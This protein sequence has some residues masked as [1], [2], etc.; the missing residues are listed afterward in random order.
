MQ[1]P[2]AAADIETLHAEEAREGDDALARALALVRFLRLRCPWDAKQT[3]QTLRPYLLE[4][5]H[6]V[7][8]AIRA[9]DD[10]GLRGELGD[11]LLNVAFQIVLAEE[12]GAFAAADVVEALE[13][14]M[15][16]R[17]PHVYGDADAP[18]DWESLKAAER[19]SPDDP[20]HGVSGGLD[21]LSRAARVQ[22]RMAGFG[23]D[24]PDLA[25][26]VEKVRE[27]TAEL[28][29]AAAEEASGSTAP[30]APPR[31]G[32]ASPE[33]VEEVGDL[34]FAVVNASRWAGVHPANALLGAVEKFER[35]CR[36]M[37]ER[38]ESRGLDWKNA[39]LATLDAVWEEVKADE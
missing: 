8:D 35:R 12:R 30:A 15:E 1:E 7:A 39:D 27:E 29:R 38:A 19:E 37:I 23:F 2:T 18:P 17:H 5:A 33:V 28:E 21:P 32:E 25:G 11:L 22:E 26:P 4:E 13:A 16:A 20:F 34:L 31:I 6:E 10:A 24:W 3:P 36:R 9:G 14:K